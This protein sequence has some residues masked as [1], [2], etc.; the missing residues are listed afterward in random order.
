VSS[1]PGER[2]YHQL[3]ESHSLRDPT[4]GIGEHSATSAH[5]HHTHVAPGGLPPYRDLRDAAD[6]AVLEEAPLPQGAGT[7]DDSDVGEL[8]RPL[9]EPFGQERPDMPVADP[10]S[11]QHDDPQHGGA[12][13]Q[14]TVFTPEAPTSR[15]HQVAL[16]RPASGRARASTST[17]GLCGARAAVV[18]AGGPWR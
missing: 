7:V 4:Q 6:G 13:D 11:G 1:T 10:R 12:P 5:D 15:R 17:R 8:R 9:E 3:L 14:Q 18:T 2:P 16:A